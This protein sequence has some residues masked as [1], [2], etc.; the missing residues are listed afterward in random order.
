MNPTIPHKTRDP[1]LVYLESACDSCKIGQL[2]D[3]G[4]SPQ[5]HRL[6]VAK[7]ILANLYTMHNPTRR[8]QNSASGDEGLSR[9]Y[10]H[11][12]NSAPA[13]DHQGHASANQKHSRPAPWRDL[14]TEKKFPAERSRAIAK[15]RHRNHQAYVLR[16]EH[17]E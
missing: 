2:R 3:I 5:I 12:R 13:Y 10:S 4:A 15:G 8:L 17:S 11:L 14:F 6:A 1:R 9:N 16:S 7:R